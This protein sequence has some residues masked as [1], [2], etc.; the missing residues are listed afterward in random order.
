MFIQVTLLSRIGYKPI[1]T[2]VN[3]PKETNYES[4]KSKAKQ[5][6]IERICAQRHMTIQDLRKYE[7]YTLK[8]RVV[9]EEKN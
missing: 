5:R 1:S 4:A 7:Y 2:I 9:E 8:M 6:G 3:L